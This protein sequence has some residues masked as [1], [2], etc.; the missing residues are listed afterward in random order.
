MDSRLIGM[1]F[2]GFMTKL[3]AAGLA[4]Y[5]GLEAYSYITTTFSSIHLP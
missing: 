1:L 3:Y 2:S 4:V 5:V